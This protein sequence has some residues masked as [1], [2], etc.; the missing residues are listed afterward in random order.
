MN[1]KCC[2]NT[3][4]EEFK[5][6]GNLKNA[7]AKKIQDKKGKIGVV[8]DILKCKDTKELKELL[9]LVEKRLKLKFEIL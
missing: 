7:I 6:F 5:D 2:Y 9:L 1:Y 8:F 4:I 3:I